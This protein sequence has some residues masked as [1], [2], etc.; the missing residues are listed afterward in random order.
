[1]WNDLL[2]AEKNK[3]TL[4]E[5][6]Y[7]MLLVFECLVPTSK[8]SLELV[9][10][11]DTILC[12]YIKI[13]KDK[14]YLFIDLVNELLESNDSIR[15]SEKYWYK[16]IHF[17]QFLFLNKFNINNI[18]KIF[19]PDNKI[20]SKLIEQIKNRKKNIYLVLLDNLEDLNQKTN[21]E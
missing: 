21:Q 12:P 3:I 2:N 4:D 19:I 14:K 8:A 15:F 5:L 16:R 7:S 10:V 17:T 11:V 6:A 20:F 1:M 18:L 13:F 9:T